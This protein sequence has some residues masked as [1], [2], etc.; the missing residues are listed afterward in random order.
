MSEIFAALLVLVGT[1]IFLWGT[2]TLDS[3][4]LRRGVAW[5]VF[6]IVVPP[7]GLIVF[8]LPDLRS[9]A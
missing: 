2:F 3:S 1:L 5:F 9:T 4:I 8:C 7:I 6:C